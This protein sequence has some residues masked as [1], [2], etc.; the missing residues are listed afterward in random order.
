MGRVFGAERTG[1]EIGVGGVEPWRECG[2]VE[3]ERGR[4]HTEE[5]IEPQ[6]EFCVVGLVTA[7]VA[8]H[9]VMHCL[10]GSSLVSLG[11][12]TILNS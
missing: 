7:V 6:I 2:G 12:W 11:L 1:M 4:V 3:K 5:P 9:T 10:G 8:K